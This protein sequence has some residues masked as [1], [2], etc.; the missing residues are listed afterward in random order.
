[1]HN[2]SVTNKYECDMNKFIFINRIW[3]KLFIS[4]DIGYL[5]EDYFYV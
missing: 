1:M 4:V 2:S 3:I 5:T